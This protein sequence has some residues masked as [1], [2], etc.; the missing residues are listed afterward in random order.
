M[1]C[2]L[3]KGYVTVTHQIYRLLKPQAGKIVFKYNN[4]IK[5]F[6]NLQVQQK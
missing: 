4:F 3:N 2:Y 6:V 5:R 1:L